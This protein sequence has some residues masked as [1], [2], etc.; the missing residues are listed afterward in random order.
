MK[1]SKSDGSAV[2]VEIPFYSVRNISC[3]EDLEQNRKV[4]TGHVPA[5]AVL[6]L[7]T[8]ENVRDYLVDAEGKKR[9]V[10]TNVH[11]AILDTLQ[12]RPE[13]FSILNGGL[14]LVARSCEVDEKSKVL[15][16]GSPS[17]INGSQ[18]QGVLRQ[19]FSGDD[20]DK[21]I[22]L[23]VTFELIVT[24]DDD[25]IA[26]ISIARNFQNDV[27]SISIAGRRGQL[28]ELEEA[29]TAANGTLKL[30]KKESQFSGSEFLN[31]EK[32][33]QVIA[34][35]TPPSLLNKEEDDCQV[36]AY[37]RREKCIKDFTRIQTEAKSNNP[38]PESVALY[39]Y[40]I[41]IAP[42]AWDLY[43]KWKSHPGFK[44]TGIR[45][46]TRDKQNEIVDVPDGITFPILSALA[47]FATKQDG[48]P[49]SISPPALFDDDELIK[50]AKS[51]YQQIAL[52]KP[53]L[54]GKSRPC[55][56][57]LRQIASLYRRLAR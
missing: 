51:A 6:N 54:M 27:A 2:T 8:D 20:V 19:Y 46:I 31:T 15:R 41:Q 57:Q 35:I 10:M 48:E 36:Y 9:K 44:G 21:E 13:T 12:N 18:T 47:V 50:S 45:A 55:Y 37:N 26:E 14:V 40:F 42:Q 5:L 38:P 25:L 16:L 34:V 56:T 17:I 53:H 30:R 23:H 29:M 32:L 24:D 7:S 33:L 28:N 3:P 22:S 39:E 49:W 11:R 52:S 4:Y 1:M 43:L